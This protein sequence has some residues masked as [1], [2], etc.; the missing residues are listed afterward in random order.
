MRIALRK[1]NE[2]FPKEWHVATFS[3]EHNHELL[4][5]QEVCF[6]PSYR[7]ITKEDEKRIVMLKE[8][9]LSVKQIMRVMEVEKDI[10]HG[11][12][13]FL[14]KDVHNFLSKLRE[15]HS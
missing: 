8:C 7:T 4:S 11:Q 3:L 2:I 15:M 1:T 9:G 14:S 5:A 13:H 6:L 10:P 12:L